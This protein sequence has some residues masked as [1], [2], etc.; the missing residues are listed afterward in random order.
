MTFE[1]E[2]ER[3]HWLTTSLCLLEGLIDSET[4][5][6]S[7]RIYAC[8]NQLGNARPAVSSEG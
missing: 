8:V 3:Y 5:K 6:M 1:A 7:A 2:D 4:K